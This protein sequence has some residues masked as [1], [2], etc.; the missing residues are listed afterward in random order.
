MTKDTRT[1]EDTTKKRQSRSP[2]E[3]ASL[4]AQGKA[5]IL[6]DGRAVFYVDS[7]GDPDAEG[8][9]PTCGMPTTRPT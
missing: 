7:W 3:L 5:R 4:V 2:L 8:K 1:D 6:S 9:C